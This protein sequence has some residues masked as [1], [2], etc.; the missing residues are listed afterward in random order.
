MSIFAKLKQA[1]KTYG[2]GAMVDSFGHI[3]TKSMREK[4]E[5]E[6]EQFWKDLSTTERILGRELTVK[7]QWEIMQRGEWRCAC[8]GDTLTPSSKDK[9]VCDTCHLCLRLNGDKIDFIGNIHENPEL[10][11]GE[12]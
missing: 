4:R 6:A 12:E 11:G 8:C 3:T 1:K 10:L 9:V 7:E 2:D 5:A